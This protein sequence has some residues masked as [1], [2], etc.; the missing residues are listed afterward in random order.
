MEAPYGI[1]RQIDRIE[2]NMADRMEERRQ[3]FGCERGPGRDLLW[4]NK[5]RKCGPTRKQSVLRRQ[6]MFARK[7]S[8]FVM[9]LPQQLH[10]LDFVFGVCN[11]QCSERGVAYA[12]LYNCR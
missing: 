10:R 7:Q 9:C 4:G 12:H 3:T 2:F 6:Q 8:Q 11:A 1:Q 5:A